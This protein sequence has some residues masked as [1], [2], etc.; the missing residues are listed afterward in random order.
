LKISTQ[1]SRGGENVIIYDNGDWIC[2]I[3]LS[4]ANSK[5]SILID[6]VYACSDWIIAYD[7][8]ANIGHVHFLK[9]F[10]LKYQ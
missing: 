2:G 6:Y 9:E 4:L 7:G 1:I 8:C 5:I 3:Y 10:S